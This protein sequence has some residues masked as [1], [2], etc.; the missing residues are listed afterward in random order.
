MITSVEIANYPEWW[1][2]VGWWRGGELILVRRVRRY[3]L[4]NP[5]YLSSPRYLSLSI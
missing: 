4:T 1:D 5:V 3:S 2:D